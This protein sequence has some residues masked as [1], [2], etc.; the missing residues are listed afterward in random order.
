MK[1]SK[2]SQLVLVSA[3]GLVLATVLSGCLYV[4]VDFVYVACSGGSGTNGTGQIQIYAVDSASGALRPS[5]TTVASG[6]SQPV[7]LVAT[8]DY[9]NLYVAN[10]SNSSV[11]HFTIGDFGQLTQ[12]DAVTVPFVPAS[13]AVNTAGT[14]LYVAGG[15]TPGHVA[16]YPLSSGKIGTLASNTSLVVPGYA[17]DVLIA[18]AVTVLANNAGVYVTAYDQSAYNPGGTVTSSANPGWLFGFAVG[19]TGALTA[20]TGSPYQAG[21]KPNAVTADPRSLFVYATDFASNELIGYTIQNGTAL[22]FMLNGPFKTG[23]EP[24]ALTIDPRGLYVYVTDAL[25]N[26]ISGYTLTLSNG[27]PSSNGGTSGAS[28]GYSTDTEPVSI[29]VDPSQGVF[30]YTANYLGNSITGSHLDPN[31]GS[32]SPNQATPYPTGQYPAAIAAI[33]HGNHAIQIVTP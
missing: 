7:S 10:Q 17:S 21:V 31:T 27:T 15:S 28:G 3:S 1:L 16:V 9:A 12:S 5:G 19:S 23:S 8:A 26:S 13:I 14:Y 2:V 30:V 6:G 4:T 33:P 24:S 32:L 18:T 29:L 22:S 20:A 25:Q 11:V